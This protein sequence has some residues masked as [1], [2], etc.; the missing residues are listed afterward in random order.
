MFETLWYATMLTGWVCLTVIAIM[1]PAWW[2]L[3]EKLGIRGW[4]SLIPF[5]D[6]Y[7]LS[8][9]TRGKTLAT[10]LLGTNV[11]FYVLCLIQASLK[12]DAM[13]ASYL[14]YDYGY[15]DIDFVSCV[16]SPYDGMY[17]HSQEGLPVIGLVI[18]WVA[19]VA[20]L[21]LTIDVLDGVSHEFGHGH[22][23]TVG[24][25]LLP[26]VF[27][28]ILAFSENEQVIEEDPEVSE[29]F[30][31]KPEESDTTSTQGTESETGTQ[32]AKQETK[33]VTNTQETVTQ[34]PADIDTDV[35]DEESTKTD[36][37]QDVN[38]EKTEA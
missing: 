13:P 19:A 31:E 22:G 8:K 2:M 28:P 12:A 20:L 3:F 32:E 21:V 24:L 11:L 36:E 25:V 17:V 30:E 23:F 38:E 14:S 7:E 26:V 27:V 35:S 4:K 5:Y 34:E 1:Y 29:A 33:S 9:R 6:G 16:R 10:W 37:T 15:G 18:L